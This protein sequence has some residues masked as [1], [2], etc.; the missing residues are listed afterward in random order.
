MN[1]KAIKIGNSI[2]V[3]IPNYITKFLGI[4]KGTKLDIDLQGKK[5][6]IKKEEE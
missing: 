6:I 4:Q 2:G 5:I 3:I 1:S